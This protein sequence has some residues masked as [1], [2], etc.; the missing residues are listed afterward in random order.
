[1]PDS[2]MEY[3]RRFSVS[4]STPTSMRWQRFGNWAQI[5]SAVISAAGL[6]A[7]FVQVVRLDQSYQQSLRATEF[8]DRNAR[9]SSARQI[10]LGYMNA[11]LQYP[12]FIKPDYGKLKEGDAVEFER[13]R[14]FVSYFV[15]AHD[16]VADVID[17]EQWQAA[18]YYDLPP[19]LPFLCQETPQFFRQFYTV[20]RKRLDDAMKEASRSVPECKDKQ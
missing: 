17:D 1:M 11:G 18:F 3:W 8:A 15:F 16:E 9:Q 20:V 2:K 6:T 4:K 7:I 12:Q 13:Y 19:H 5:A 14:W 10:Y